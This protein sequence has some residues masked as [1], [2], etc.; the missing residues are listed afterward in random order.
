LLAYHLLRSYKL[1]LTLQKRT[2]HV[3]EYVKQLSDD[4]KLADLCREVFFIAFNPYS[5]L[6]EG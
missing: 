3:L 5:L 1:R 6:R 2:D 4:S